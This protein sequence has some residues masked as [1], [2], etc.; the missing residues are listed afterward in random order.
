V[1]TRFADGAADIERFVEICR[2]IERTKNFNAR[3]SAEMLQLLLRPVPDCASVQVVLIVSQVKGHISAG[4]VI[5]RVGQSMSMLWAAVDRHYSAERVGEAAHWAAV[6]WGLDHNC[7]RYDLEGIDPVGNKGVY[8]FKSHFGG[9]EVTLH[10]KSFRAVSTLGRLLL[11]V[12]TR[13]VKA[14]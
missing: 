5:A 2:G 14:Q 6:R 9:R 4:V 12:I 10:G 7:K 3:I 13:V 8:R 11:P 1:V